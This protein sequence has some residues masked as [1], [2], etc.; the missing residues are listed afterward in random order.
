MA[1]SDAGVPIVVRVV[2]E[3]KNAV[4]TCAWA[5]PPVVDLS[6]IIA[7]LFFFFPM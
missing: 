5:S 3:I 4:G 2:E 7:A 6:S 1:G